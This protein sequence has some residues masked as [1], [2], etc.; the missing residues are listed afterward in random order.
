MRRTT[1]VAL[2]VTVLLAL[3]AGAAL[4]GH[5]EIQCPVPSA[6]P[7]A[8]SPPS[9]KGTEADE[10]MKGT[11]SDD[12]MAG[13]GG[14]DLMYGLDG[15]DTVAGEDGEDMLG[16]DF[17]GSVAHEQRIL[18]LFANGKDPGEDKFYGGPGKDEIYARECETEGDQ[19][20]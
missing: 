5:M 10:D 1:T 9:C 20:G 3:F 17:V 15:K 19:P 16:G 18:F 4:A 14:D 6:S 11:P 2:V 8:G 13:G 12:K 7:P